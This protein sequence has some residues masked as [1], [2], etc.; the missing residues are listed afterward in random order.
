M[1]SLEEAIRQSGLANGDTVSFHHHLREGDYVINMVMDAIA[2]M[3]FRDICIAP[4]SLNEVNDPILKHIESGVIGLM[5]TSGMRGELGLA[6]SRGTYGFPVLFRSHGGRA[7]AIE[8]GSLSID[9]AFIA[10]PSCDRFGNITGTLGPSAC[11]SLGYAVPDAH[12]A[13]SV[14]A[15]TDN[16]IE[17]PLPEFSIPGCLVDFVAKVDVIGDPTRISA[18]AT[19]ITRNPVD[20]VIAD[21]AARIIHSSRVYGPGFSMQFGTG[22]ASL[23]IARYLSEYMRQDGVRASF[24]LGG[25]TAQCTQMLEAGLTDAIF[26]VQCFDQTAVKSLAAHPRHAEIGVSHYANPNTAGAMV[27]FLDVVVLS[28]ME[29]DMDFNVNVLTGSDGVVRGASGGHCDAAAGAKLT[30]VVAPGV[31]GRLP[32]VLDRVGTIITPGTDVACVITDLG[33][34]WNPRYSDLAPSSGEA[35]VDIMEIGELRAR[36]ERLTGR[37][38]PLPKGDLI[39]GE[40]EYRDG[41]IIDVIRTVV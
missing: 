7:R 27:D 14:V 11:G 22:G 17:G 35:G 39:V 26:D 25:I 12:Y 2:G 19:R 21:K 6:L 36:I 38:E 24:I 34:A 4:S 23:A 30:I 10:A 5:T 32:L 16:L 40:V 31:R 13:A 37:P 41:S 28:A 15:V 18:G 20:L 29:V 33:V 1:P 8:E 9:V 3:G